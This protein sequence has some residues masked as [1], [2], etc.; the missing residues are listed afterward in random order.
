[1]GSGIRIMLFRKLGILRDA[2]QSRY[3]GQT[4][5]ESCRGP[6]GTIEGKQVSWSG[7]ESKRRQITWKK[8]G[9]LD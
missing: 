4:E 9:K 5:L 1:M 2:V 6:G 8:S 7:M 3:G